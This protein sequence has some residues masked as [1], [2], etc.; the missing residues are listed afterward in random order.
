MLLK[1][2]YNH[3]LYL[4]FFPERHV[5]FSSL[6]GHPCCWRNYFS[7]TFNV[8]SSIMQ[9]CWLILEICCSRE[10]QRNNQSFESNLSYSEKNCVFVF[11]QLI[12]AYASRERMQWRGTIWRSSQRS[13]LAAVNILACSGLTNPLSLQS[14][15]SPANV[16][17]YLN[18][19]SPRHVV[20]FLH[21]FIEHPISRMLTK[22][23]YLVNLPF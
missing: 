14:A 4:F 10:M 17:A 5:C 8:Q 20:T 13:I 7:M 9:T 12:E 19:P 1:Q 6:Y 3:I 23:I 2:N 11:A 21:E 15:G 22:L 16:H 18:E